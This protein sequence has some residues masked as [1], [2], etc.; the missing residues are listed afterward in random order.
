MIGLFSRV[1]RPAYSSPY[2]TC[3]S[4]TEKRFR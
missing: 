3:V 2:M 4:L 1:L